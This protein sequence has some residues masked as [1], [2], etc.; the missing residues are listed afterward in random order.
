MENLARFEPHS[1]TAYSN[2]RLLDCINKPEKLIKR[3][4]EI[5]L[6]GIAI[7]DHETVAGHM[8]INLL[9]QSLQ[10]DYP[11]FKIAL[12]NEIYLTESREV[13]QKYFHFLQLK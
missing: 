10:K 12:G 6:S 4:I 8:E 13:G 5:G 3:A 1:H 9:A 2:F 7:T 11:D